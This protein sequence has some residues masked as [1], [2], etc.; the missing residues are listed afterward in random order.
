MT[1]VSPGMAG[2]WCFGGGRSAWLIAS[3]KAATPMIL[4]S[5]AA[6]AVMILI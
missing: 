6:T 3:R 2:Q 4:R 5:S 1:K